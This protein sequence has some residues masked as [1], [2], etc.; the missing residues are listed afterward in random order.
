[1]AGTAEPLDFE[2]AR[3]IFVMRFDAAAT[4]TIRRWRGAALL[5][6]LRSDELSR[7]DRG[8][9][10]PACPEANAVE[11]LSIGAELV[12]V[13]ALPGA[14]VLGAIARHDQAGGTAAVAVAR[15]SPSSVA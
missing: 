11:A 4:E 14:G 15:H 8:G 2:R 6:C 7:P 3:V 12:R 5:A 1:M 13:P 9:D 10:S